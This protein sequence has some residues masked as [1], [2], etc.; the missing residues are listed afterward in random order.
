M[1]AFRAQQERWV[2]GAGLTLRTLGRRIALGRAPAGARA[3]MLAH[4]TRHARQPLL[5]AASLA[6]TARALG[7]P[8]LTPPRLL[9]PFALALATVAVVAYYGLAYR[10]ARRSAF[11][12]LCAPLLLPLTVGL[13]LS[14]SAALIGGLFGRRGG[15]FHRTPKGGDDRRPPAS[16]MRWI[17]VALG[18]S[19]LAGAAMAFGRGE[20]A[21]PAGALLI[22]SGWLW[23]ALA[24]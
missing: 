13:S 5:V 24:P 23:V 16:P 15:G 14:L 4:L 3:T 17:E 11:A 7:A 2:R 6:V 20:L 19:A 1:R 22:A 12:A 18:A 9:W 21:L 10:R 8:A